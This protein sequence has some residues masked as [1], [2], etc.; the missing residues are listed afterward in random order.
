MTSYRPGSFLHFHA[1]EFQDRLEEVEIPGMVG[2]SWDR[3]AAYLLWLAE[4][5]DG[6]IGIPPLPKKT[7]ETTYR[8]AKPAL[9]KPETKQRRLDYDDLI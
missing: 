4:G 2:A 7:I 9:P 8:A 1:N 5:N 6:P 3:R